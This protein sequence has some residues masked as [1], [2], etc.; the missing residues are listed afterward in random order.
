MVF[1]VL[2]RGGTFFYA[3]CR[4]LELLMSNPTWTRQN[5][6][7]FSATTGHRQFRV[8]LL[9]SCTNLI[10]FPKCRFMQKLEVVLPAIER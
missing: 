5:I 4:W 2:S 10:K 6:L 7:Q 1:D 9:T 3:S 8:G